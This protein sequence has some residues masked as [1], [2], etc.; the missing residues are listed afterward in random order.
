MYLT[1]DCVMLI[2]ASMTF[3][4]LLCGISP[5]VSQSVSQFVPV[6]QRTKLF[7]IVLH[8]DRLFSVTLQA[9]TWP[10]RS[11]QGPLWVCRSC[12]TSSRTTTTTTS[13]IRRLRAPA[14]STR[15]T[16][17]GLDL[18]PQ[19]RKV[20]NRSLNPQRRKS[21]NPQRR[22]GLNPLRRKLLNGEIVRH[23]KERTT[24]L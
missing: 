2:K 8:E 14:T 11:P 19:H 6:A 21:L 1:M 20:L 16:Q 23:P 15:K 3:H 9:S 5:S 13:M 22:K 12:S 24:R 17:R 4:E 18:N 10:A 7:R